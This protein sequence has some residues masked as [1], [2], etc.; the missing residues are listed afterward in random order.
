MCPVGV[1]T[2][3][4]LPEALSVCTIQPGGSAEGGWKAGADTGGSATA[5]ILVICMLRSCFV[6]NTAS[7]DERGPPVVAGST[8]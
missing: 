3:K 8:D 1:Y 7:L 2:K 4:G 5:W 6:S